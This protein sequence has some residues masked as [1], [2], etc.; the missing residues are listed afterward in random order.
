MPYKRYICLKIH[1]TYNIIN[2]VI[3]IIIMVYIKDWKK[4]YTLDE[5]SEFLDSRI[6][7]RSKVVSKN[8]LY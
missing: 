6:K 8:L 4:Y 1:E 5:A 7:E 3:I 2:L